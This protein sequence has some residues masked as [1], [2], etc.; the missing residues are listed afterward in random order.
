MRRCLEEA[1]GW[2]EPIERLMRALEVVVTDVVLESALRVDDVREHRAPEKLVPQRLPESLHLA[3]RLRVLRPTADVLDAPALEVL[4]EL[5]LATPHRVL[6]A[7][8]GQH[9]RRL[10]VRG[11]TTLERLHHQRRLLVV[12]ERVPDHESAV[13]VHEHANVQT[14]RASQ[15]KREDVRLPQLVRRRALEAPR[16]V[17]AF[18]CRHRC[19]DKTLGVEDF[20]HLL[21]TDTQCRE[22]CQYVADSPRAPVPVFALERHDPLVDRRAC[23][24]LPQPGLAPPATT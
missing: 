12:R 7:V 9:L 5:G 20:P 23:L 15:P 16:C 21:F 17:L 18:R 1:V 2:H 3:Q 4:L 14:L 11:D 19:L 22:P 13:V 6:P 24:Q 8:V 10:T